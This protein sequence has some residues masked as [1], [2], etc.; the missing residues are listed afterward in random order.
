VQAAEA[1][2]ELAHRVVAI[3]PVQQQQQQQQQQHM[4]VQLDGGI[5]V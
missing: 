4:A 2:A 5:N 1:G 3:T